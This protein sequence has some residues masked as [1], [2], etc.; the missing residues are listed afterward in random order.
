MAVKKKNDSNRTTD[1]AYS[2]ELR[3]VQ[4]KLRC[5]QHNG[6]NRWCYVNKEMP[7]EHVPLGYEEISLWARKIVSHHC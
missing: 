6:P 1:F 5:A 4:E 7:H 2:A 3:S